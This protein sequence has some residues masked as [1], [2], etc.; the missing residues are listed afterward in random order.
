[1]TTKLSADEK[2]EYLD[3]TYQTADCVGECDQCHREGPLWGLPY[4]LDD[5]PDAGWQYCAECFRYIVNLS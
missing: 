1:M 2:R 5:E 3:W 4:A